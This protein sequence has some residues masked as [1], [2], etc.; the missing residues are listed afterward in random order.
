MP[1][2]NSV[3]SG[4]GGKLRVL[5][6]ETSPCDIFD[7]LNAMPSSDTPSLEI[8]SVSTASTLLPTI[9]LVNPE[10]VFVD[11]A[12]QPSA[13]LDLVRSVHRT[14]PNIPLIILAG[15][16]DGEN[17]RQCL[18]EGATDCLLKSTPDPSVVERVLRGAL[19]RNTVNRLTDLLR[20]PLTRLYN[21]DGFAALASRTLQSAERSAGRMILLTAEVEN[22]DE[23]GREFGPSIAEQ[24]VRD[25]AALLSKS[26]RRTDIVARL[27]ENRFAVLALD[28][29]EP[30]GAI[31][32]QRVERHL[33]ALNRSRAPWGDIA[34]KLATAFWS[35][36][37]S[38]PFHALLQMLP[39]CSSSLAPEAAASPESDASASLR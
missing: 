2:M 8:T 27:A 19:E 11:L 39:M 1:P 22:L 17:A 33:L 15:S 38:R 10:V 9:Q 5:V 16:A 30:T 29:L 25:I 7:A 13:P 36:G 32:R 20:D 3:A 23:L 28:A 35:A 24:A 12:L 18:Q 37:A 34:L 14:L 6:A 26:F 21:L 31:M 4:S